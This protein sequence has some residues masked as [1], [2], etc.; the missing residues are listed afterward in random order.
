M[1]EIQAISGVSLG[2]TMLITNNSGE[3]KQNIDKKTQ[4]LNSHVIIRE[5]NHLDLKEKLTKK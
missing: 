2:Y 4:T 3:S 5:K 1:Y